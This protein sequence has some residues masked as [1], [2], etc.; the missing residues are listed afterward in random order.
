M[1]FFAI[2]STHSFCFPAVASSHA[3]LFLLAIV[4][5]KERKKPAAALDD[6]CTCN[7]RSLPDEAHKPGDPSTPLLSSFF[8]GDLHFNGNMEVPRAGDYIQVDNLPVRV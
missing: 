3:D 2:P 1:L 7:T 5:M 6:L 4:H 8:R